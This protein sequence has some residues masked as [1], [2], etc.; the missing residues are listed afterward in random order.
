MHA[1]A[2]ALH[3]IA[4]RAL[5]HC[6]GDLA[7]PSPSFQVPQVPKASDEPVY[8]AAT[9]TRRY[10]LRVYSLISNSAGV[11]TWWTFQRIKLTTM[12]TAC[13]RYTAGERWRS[14]RIMA[15]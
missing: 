11:R 7:C 1:S 5:G 3:S 6:P 12:Y 9:L 14:G 4:S 13:T 10:L 15:E 8:I 2:G